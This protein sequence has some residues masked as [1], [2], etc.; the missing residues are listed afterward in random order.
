MSRFFNWGVFEGQ[1][2]G[3]P[4]LLYLWVYSCGATEVGIDLSK[5]FQ[6]QL[7]VVLLDLKSVMEHYL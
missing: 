5:D 4:S 3:E 6:S 7:I 1:S 2:C